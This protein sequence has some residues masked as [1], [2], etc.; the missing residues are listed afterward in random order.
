[1][2]TFLCRFKYCGEHFGREETLL[3]HYLNVHAEKILSITLQQYENRINNILRKA[4]AKKQIP[5]KK[6]VK[7]R[8]RKGSVW[9]VRG[10]L[11]GSSRRH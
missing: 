11:P 10:G 6:P 4:E 7:K 8:K 3:K 5:T 2:A 9:A 1:M